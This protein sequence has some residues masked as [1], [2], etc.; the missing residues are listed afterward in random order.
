MITEKEYEEIARRLRPRLRA[1]G[2]QLLGTDAE[3]EDVAQ[4][5]LLRL[6]LLRHRMA[7]A[8][9]AEALL[10]TMARNVSVS[11]WRRRRSVLAVSDALTVAS[12]AGVA[13]DEGLGLLQEAVSRL[14]PSEQRLFRMRQ[15]L[16]MDV[17][18]IA[19]V[20]GMT[21]RSVSAVVSQARK[22]IVEQL[23][24]GGIL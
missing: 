11:L 5:A 2:R 4:E 24:K 21:P 1:V 13:D 16:E 7:D 20:T 14:P 6:W 22:K 10:L 12:Q 9:H 18:Q 17:P 19:A 8:G 23:K 15:E 3:G